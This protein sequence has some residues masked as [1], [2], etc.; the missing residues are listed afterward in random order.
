MPAKRGRDSREGFYIGNVLVI[1]ILAWCPT[2]QSNN[3]L[4]RAYMQ[5]KHHCYT[6]F[7]TLDDLTLT[8]SELKRVTAIVGCIKPGEEGKWRL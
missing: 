2:E 5:A 1:W 3:L 7:P 6:F 8:Q 4:R